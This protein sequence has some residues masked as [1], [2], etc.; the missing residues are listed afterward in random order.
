MLF[1]IVNWV[2]LFLWGIDVILLKEKVKVCRRKKLW[3][4]RSNGQVWW[5]V[6]GWRCGI[7]QQ[8]VGLKKEEGAAWEEIVTDVVGVQ[9]WIQTPVWKQQELVPQI[10]RVVEAPVVGGSDSWPGCFVAWKWGR[11]QMIQLGEKGVVED[12]QERK[13]TWM[14]FWANWITNCHSS[15]QWAY[16]PFVGWMCSLNIRR[17][18]CNNILFCCNF[19]FLLML[20]VEARFFSL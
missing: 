12:F 17:V 7:K 9:G 10:I 14:Y 1:V 6:G 5:R 4:S 15:S 19:T 18:I 20:G 16:T 8:K 3:G 2:V 11:G 13:G